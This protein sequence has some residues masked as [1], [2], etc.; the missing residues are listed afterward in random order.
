MEGKKICSKQT[1]GKTIQKVAAK[2]T[3]EANKIIKANR[4]EEM[5]KKEWKTE[6]TNI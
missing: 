6:N 1:N 3:E 2:I 4:S 5:K